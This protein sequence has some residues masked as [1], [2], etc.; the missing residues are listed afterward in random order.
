M[1]V[2][3]KRI[4][5]ESFPFLGRETRLVA[6]CKARAKGNW[7]TKASPTQAIELMVYRIRVKT[8]SYIICGYRFS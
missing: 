1:G 3:K 6:F 5:V 8:M 2:R 4:V 7:E